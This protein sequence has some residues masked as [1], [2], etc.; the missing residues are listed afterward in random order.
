MLH[1]DNPQRAYFDSVGF[2]YCKKENIQSPHSLTQH[3]RLKHPQEWKH[4]EDAKK[5]KERLEDRELQLAILASIKP[6]VSPIGETNEAPL[7]VSDKPPKKK[8]K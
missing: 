2:R 3:M 7:Y 4:I 1:K 6:T 5:E 8:R